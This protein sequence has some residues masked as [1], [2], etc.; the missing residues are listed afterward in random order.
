M[1]ILLPFPRI[2]EGV[3]SLGPLYPDRE[4]RETPGVWG[5][6][7][8]RAGHLL[9]LRDK[10]CVPMERVD[11]VLDGQ[12]LGEVRQVDEVFIVIAAGVEM[13]ARGTW[14]RKAPGGYL[15]PPTLD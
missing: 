6:A 1:E 9:R 2:P 7:R 15:L 14:T 3:P 5:G 12:L 11:Q 13:G 8:D 4:R 10:S